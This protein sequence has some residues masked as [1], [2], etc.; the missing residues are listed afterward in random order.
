MT[1]L[2]ACA[3]VAN[4]T[5]SSFAFRIRYRTLEGARHLGPLLDGDAEYADRLLKEVLKDKQILEADIVRGADLEPLQPLFGHACRHGIAADQCADCSRYSSRL[6]V[7]INV[8]ADRLRQSPAE[9]V[10][11]VTLYDVILEAAKS[12]P[13]P[14][15]RT[16]LVIA[17]WRLDRSRL[18]L[19]GCDYHPDAAKVMTAVY[20]SR[21]LIAKGRLLAVAGGVFKVT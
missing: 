15:T 11:A 14:F 5:P 21:G 1:H 8:L 9:R 6:S 12:L 4:P 13:Q 20:G 17:A 16:A 19:D 2:T 18:C 3:P 10:K 7:R